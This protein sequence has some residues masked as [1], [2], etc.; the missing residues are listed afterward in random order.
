MEEE[1]PGLIN[2][3]T[4]VIKAFHVNSVTKYCKPERFLN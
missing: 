2:A 3:S 4:G 1:I